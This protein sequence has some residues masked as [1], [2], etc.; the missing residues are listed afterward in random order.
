MD[1]IIAA[2]KNR[3]DG[4]AAEELAGLQLTERANSQRR[5]RWQAALPGKHCHEV[6]TMIADVAEFLDLPA[7]DIPPNPPPSIET[8]KNILYKSVEYVSST[9]S[10]LPNF[11]ATRKTEYF[12]D[13]PARPSS[14]P[15][16]GSATGRA[17]VGALPSETAF[18]PLHNVGKSSVPVSYRNGKEMSG[19][20]AAD[21]VTQAQPASALS[22]HGEFGPILI[23]VLGDAAKN[24][25]VWSH[26]E[27][28]AT[29]LNAV[30]RYRVAAG[31]TDYMTMLPHGAQAQTFFPA[32]HG[33]VA[34]DPDTGAILRVT[35]VADYAPPNESAVSS[36]L[37]EYGPIEIGGAPYICPL[38]SVALA[39]VPV[40]EF[41][42]VAP[43]M[44]TQLNDVAFVDYH[45]F[46]AEARMLTDNLVDNSQPAAPSK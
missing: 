41:P 33:E 45:L 34:V 31:Q 26:W 3:P 27:Q 24:K 46:H 7:A 22:T 8:Q 4:K 32:Y 2:V 28:G 11:F 15:S 37:V 29:G 40:A 20:K 17:A 9:M 21:E 16:L 10:R 13:A 19:S 44:Q 5:A 39:K 36:M 25:I 12:K 1:R 42:T 35:V 14:G 18:E 43:V 30:F 38:K 23:V 6:L